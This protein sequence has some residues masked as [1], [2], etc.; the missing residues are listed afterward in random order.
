MPNLYFMRAMERSAIA[1][2]IC[3]QTGK[4]HEV[5]KIITIFWR[6]SYPNIVYVFRDISGSGEDLFLTNHIISR[7]LLYTISFRREI[8]FWLEYLLLLVN[9]KEAECNR[10]N[11]L[12]ACYSCFRWCNAIAISKLKLTEKRKKF[13]GIAV[14][15]AEI[16]PNST[17]EKFVMWV[18]D[19]SCL[20]GREKSRL[21]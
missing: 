12:I 10:R 19:L 1:D 3:E 21:N 15:R 11:L 9:C 18:D 16:I 5:T 7:G 6:F 8:H 4:G 17:K 13:I 20:R 14:Q 2:E